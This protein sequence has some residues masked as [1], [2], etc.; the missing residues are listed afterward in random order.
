MINDFSIL[1]SSCDKFSDLWKT[2]ISLLKKNWRGDLPEI[3]LVTDK[4]TDFMDEDIKVVAFS[5]DMP[6]RLK[7]ACERINSNYVLITL[8][9][10]FIINTIEEEKMQYLK[11]VANR[12]SIDYLQLYHRRYAKKK[13]YTEIEDIRKIDLST[14]YAV[15]LYPAI[16]KKDF[17]VSCVDEDDTPW[18]FE[19]EL[20]MK[21]IDYNA[22]CCI[23]N[24][25][26]FQILDVV[27]K[28]KVLHKANRFLRRNN[29][30][31]GD[32]PLASRVE[33]MKLTIADYIWWYAPRWFYKAV[34][35][36]AEKAGMQFYSKE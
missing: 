32:R 6:V 26:V 8:D 33:E 13:Y 20:T 18:R 11:N 2:N 14:K 3:Y 24:A 35:K 34:R 25:G 7:K 23:S 16:W 1:I 4:D 15:S 17:F 29:L 12:E 9:D 27:R 19:P 10:Y 21:A 22:N 28:G 5:G 31:I 36:I 30:D